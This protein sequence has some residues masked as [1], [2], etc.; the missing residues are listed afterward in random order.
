MKKIFKKFHYYLLGL[1]DDTWF[2]WD[3]RFV[4]EFGVR[5][6]RS[7]SVIMVIN[8]MTRRMWV[9][10]GWPLS[11]VWRQRY[12]KMKDTTDLKKKH[13]FFD[14]I[15]WYMILLSARACQKPWYMSL[16]IKKNLCTGWIRKRKLFVFYFYVPNLS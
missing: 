1:L 10:Q 8:E 3:L 15:T 16:I 2:I 5:G 11:I 6:E 14:S 7:T 4:S 9:T 12:L 13:F